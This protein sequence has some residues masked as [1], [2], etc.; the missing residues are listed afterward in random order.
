[1][2]RPDELRNSLEDPALEEWLARQG[3]G[4]IHNPTVLLEDSWPEDELVDEL[5]A[6][7]HDRRG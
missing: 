5:V 4:P 7:L 3:E 1:M 6:A 2:E